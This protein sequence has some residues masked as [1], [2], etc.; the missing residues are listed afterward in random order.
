MG[1]YTHLP[2]I[3]S[4]GYTTYRLMTWLSV[5]YL[6]YIL[7]RVMHWLWLGLLGVMHWLWLG[8]LGVMHWLWLRLLGVMH[9]LWLRLLGVITKTSVIKQHCLVIR[10]L[11]K[12]HCLVITRRVLDILFFILLGIILMILLGSIIPNSPMRHCFVMCINYAYMCI[13]HIYI[14]I[15]HINQY[16][17]P[18][19]YVHATVAL[20]RMTE[21]EESGPEGWLDNFNS[22]QHVPNNAIVLP[23]L[24]ALHKWEGNVTIPDKPVLDKPVWQEQEP[25]QEPQQEHKPEH[26]ELNWFQ[27]MSSFIFS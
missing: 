5:Q 6:K 16:R 18:R 21:T 2:H 22:F 27:T 23:L 14:C 13:N 10:R 20:V 7:P 19:S 3:L 24:E 9:W 11:I 25:E 15:S 4:C 17:P 8:L 26:V 12:R 1:T